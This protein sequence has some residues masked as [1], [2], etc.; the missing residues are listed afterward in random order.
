VGA[1][2]MKLEELI[3]ALNQSNIDMN[4]QEEI[5]ERLN[6]YENAQESKYFTIL[7]TCKEEL[8]DIFHEQQHILAKIAEL[9]DDQMEEI[10]NDAGDQ[11]MKWHSKDLKWALRNELEEQ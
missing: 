10:T 7:E 1:W 11:L 2:K 5:I 8:T 9:T 3:A 4:A 6:R